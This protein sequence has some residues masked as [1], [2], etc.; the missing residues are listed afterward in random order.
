MKRRFLRA[1]YL[2]PPITPG[3]LTKAAPPTIGDHRG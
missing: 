1:T 3:D 2:P